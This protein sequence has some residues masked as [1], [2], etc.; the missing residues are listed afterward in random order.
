M[1]VMDG[2]QATQII[3]KFAPALPIIGLT[4]HVLASEKEHCPRNGMVDH[5]AK[6][7]D[8]DKL[9]ETI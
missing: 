6:P 9:V 8:A 1:P 7:M 2:H 4:A 3:H 5:V